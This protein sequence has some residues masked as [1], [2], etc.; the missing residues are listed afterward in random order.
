MGLRHI[1]VDIWW[2][3]YLELGERIVVCHSPVP[4]IQTWQI[5]EAA[6]KRNI[7]LDWDPLKLSCLKTNRNFTEVMLEFRDFLL[8]PGN[9][10]EIVFIYLDTKFNPTPDQAANGNAAMLNVLG[11]MIFLP[12]AGDPRTWT[13]EALLKAGKRVVVEDHEKVVQIDYRLLTGLTG[14]G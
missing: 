3:G 10:N 1:E 13:V 7:S 9:E 2:G 11:D 12:S 4:L 14:L 5:E 6:A 8:A